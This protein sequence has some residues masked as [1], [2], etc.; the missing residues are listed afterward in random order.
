[1]QYQYSAFLYKHILFITY[2]NYLLYTAPCISIRNLTIKDILHMATS[3]DQ[4]PANSLLPRKS[5]KI[6]KDS[7]VFL[8]YYFVNPIYIHS[9]GIDNYKNIAK[10]EVL[11]LNL[12][13]LLFIY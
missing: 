12:V 2:N 13:S 3:V 4:D 10:Y 11:N 7:E 1:M 6:V 5:M 9:V 8:K